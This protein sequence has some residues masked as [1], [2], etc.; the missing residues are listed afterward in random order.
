[1]PETSSPQAPP[2][3]LPIAAEQEAQRQRPHDPSAL[4]VWFYRCCWMLLG[5]GAGGTA[6]HFCNIPGKAPP[7]AVRSASGSA[8]PMEHLE[9]G[10][11]LMGYAFSIR[12]TTLN[13]SAV[14]EVE[15]SKSNGQFIIRIERRRYVICAHGEGAIISQSI[16]D[17]R[18]EQGD[19]VLV[20][21]LGKVRIS[22]SEF[23]ALCK[24]LALRPGDTAAGQCP[25]NCS[26]QLSPSGQFLHRIHRP[27]HPIPD[28]VCCVLH[29]EEMPPTPKE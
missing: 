12:G 22:G 11:S 27:E 18:H 6:L 23:S 20:S 14:L 1:M 2:S 29:V 10:I 15:C 21:E 26:L 17:V 13:G 9:N 16:T 5:A 24:D 28:H 19:I 4:T 8:V 3:L 25:V 7:P